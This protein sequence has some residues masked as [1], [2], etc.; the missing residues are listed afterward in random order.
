MIDTDMGPTAFT[1]NYCADRQ[2]GGPHAEAVK[3]M[4]RSQVRRLTDEEYSATLDRTAP[5]CIDVALRRPDGKF[6]FA[7]RNNQPDQG[8][9]AFPGGSDM[10]GEDFLDTATR[11][12]KTP[13]TIEVPRIDFRILARTDPWAFSSREQEPQ[14]NGC[15]MVGTTVFADIHWGL[16]NSIVVRGDSSDLHWLHP[17]EIKGNPAINPWHRM[18]V[19]DAI[20]GNFQIFYEDW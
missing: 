14:T 2:L 8:A 9:L 11:H 13:Y 20:F 7:R 4:L 19:A 18:A 15:Q 16:A 1:P 6:A 10:P 5:H 3:T 17:S 12:I